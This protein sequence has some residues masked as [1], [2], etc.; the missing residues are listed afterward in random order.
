MITTEK[1]NSLNKDHN[2]GLENV[3]RTSDS[4]EGFYLLFDTMLKKIKQLEER[5]ADL[6]SIVIKDPFS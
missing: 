2:L 4:A 6:E 3:D 5:V 1:Y